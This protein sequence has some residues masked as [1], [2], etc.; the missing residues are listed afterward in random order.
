MVDGLVHLESKVSSGSDCVGRGS[1]SG[2]AS[3]VASQIVGPREDRGVH[4]G[5][6]AN[7]LVGT[8]GRAAC[9][10]AGEA[11]WDKC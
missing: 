2:C 11:V 5:V 9:D 10:Q 3:G 4:V 6:L 7:I 8:G 1:A